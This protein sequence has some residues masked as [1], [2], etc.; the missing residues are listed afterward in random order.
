MRASRVSA[1]LAAAVL[2]ASCASA[3]SSGG[4]ASQA[5]DSPAGVALDYADALRRGDVQSANA[6]VAHDRRYCP[7]NQSSR[8]QLAMLIPN[9]GEQLRTRVVTAGHTWR[10]SFF[11]SDGESSSSSGPPLVVVHE[12]GRYVVC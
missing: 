9:R 6:L 5:A 3:K 12:A 11:T 4:N 2:V 10:V 8:D 7:N 1:S